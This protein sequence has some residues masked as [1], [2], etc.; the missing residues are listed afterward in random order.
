MISVWVCA[1]ERACVPVCVCFCVCENVQ[2]RR[3][4]IISYITQFVITS[5]SFASYL[6]QKVSMINRIEL[7]NQFPWVETNDL[8]NLL[9]NYYYYLV[10]TIH[11]PSRRLLR[12]TIT[13]NHFVF[14][15]GI[16]WMGIETFYWN[17]GHFNKW[18][19]RLRMH[20]HKMSKIK[21][22]CISNVE[23]S[24]LFKYQLAKISILPIIQRNSVYYFK[25]S[26]TLT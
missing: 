9:M 8:I 10:G 11:Y 2:H 6:R 23:I 12:S 18:E 20:N 1:C 13:S 16:K 15:N 24:K 3:T 22:I 5:L 17:K 7:T 26:E 4:N 19:C 14:L 21:W 25:D